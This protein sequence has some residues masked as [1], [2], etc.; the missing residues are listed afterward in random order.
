M[1]RINKGAE[2][3]EWTRKKATPG[4]VEY[5]PIPELREA[6]LKEQGYICAYCMREIPVKKKDSHLT[7]TSKI[8]HLKCREHHSDF[9][10]DYNNMVICCPGFIDG[11]AHCDKS[12][13]NQEI[14]FN[15]FHPGLQSSISY[16]TKDGKI[17]STNLV[18]NNEIENILKLNNSMLKVNRK[19]ALDGI[20]MVLAKKKWRPAEISSKLDLWKTKDTNGKHKAYCG[21]VIWFLEK[22]VRQQN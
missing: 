7:E 11:T 15:I 2:P 6:L 19:D 1:I 4:F 8:E 22:K 3:I 12:K 5:E 13:D 10:L 14:T 21:I 16:S 17:K 18:W 9:Q 20:L